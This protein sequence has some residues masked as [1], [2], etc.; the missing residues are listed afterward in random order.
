MEPGCGCQSASQ[1]QGRMARRSEGKMQARGER[2][3]LPG[4]PEGILTRRPRQAHAISREQAREPPQ[5]R[6]QGLTPPQEPAWEWEPEQTETRKEQP[7]PEREQRS[8][9]NET[10]VLASWRPP[11]TERRWLPRPSARAARSSDRFATS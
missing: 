1:V 3:H 4:R 9:S 5:K 11:S 2:A 6:F 7:R 8:D 10:M